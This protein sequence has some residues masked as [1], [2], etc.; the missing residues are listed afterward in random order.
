M[1]QREE[2]YQ[3]QLV[4]NCESG[5]TGTAIECNLLAVYGRNSSLVCKDSE[6]EGPERPSSCRTRYLAP[7]TYQIV[8]NPPVWCNSKYA[9]PDTCLE[10]L[11]TGNASAG[12]RILWIRNNIMCHI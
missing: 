12:P 6:S 1:D 11:Y 3:S 7:R 4:D 8:L 5:I 9:S 10:L 2:R